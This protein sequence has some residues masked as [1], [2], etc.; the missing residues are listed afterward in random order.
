MIYFLQI[1][2]YLRCMRHIIHLSKDKKLK[3]ILESQKPVRLQ[4]RKKVYLH[5]C[6]SIMSQQLNTKVAHI[7][8]RRFLELYGKTEP[9]AQQILDTSVETLHSIGLSNAKASYVHN[10]CK[11]F[12]DNKITDSKLAKMSNQEVIDLLTQ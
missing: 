1:D 3:K 12:I 7:I 8:H 9:T 6:A 5:L 2:R 4:K 10:V 11:F